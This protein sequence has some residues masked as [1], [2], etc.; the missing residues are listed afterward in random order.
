LFSVEWTCIELDSPAVALWF[1][2]QNNEGVV[3]TMSGS[4]WYVNWSEGTNIRIVT[5]YLNGFIGCLSFVSGSETNPLFI[6][7]DQNGCLKLWASK[8]CD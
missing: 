7:G 8:T 3:G 5:S 2:K 4:V 6:T 1:D